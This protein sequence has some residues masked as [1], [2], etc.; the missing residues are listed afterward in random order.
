LLEECPRATT[1]HV[2]L[3][4]FRIHHSRITWAALRSFGKRIRLRFLPPRCP[5]AKRIERLWLDLHAEVTRNHQQPMINKLTKQVWRFG[6]RRRSTTKT[7]MR[8][9]A[10]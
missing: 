2:I 4:N 1:I 3:D 9:L 5:D 8:R 10:A 6:R 7:R